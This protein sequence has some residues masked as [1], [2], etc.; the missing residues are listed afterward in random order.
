MLSFLQKINSK[1]NQIE[2]KQSFGKH[3][4][5][6]CSN[7]TLEA[8]DLANVNTKINDNKYN[9]SNSGFFT[10]LRK[11]H[12]NNNNTNNINNIDNETDSSTNINNNKIIPKSPF[13]RKTN[14]SLATFNS[15]YFTTGRFTDRKKNSSNSLGI[16]IPFI[17]FIIK[18]ILIH[19]SNIIY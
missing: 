13:S 19:N 4:G 6:I 9:G 18:F 11:H 10:V 3:K 16:F 8:V 14:L 15:G 5:S 1:K 17:P 2:Q 7:S 12:K